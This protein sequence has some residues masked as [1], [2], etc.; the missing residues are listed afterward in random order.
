MKPILFVAG[1]VMAFLSTGCMTG[2]Y[3]HHERR[4]MVERDSL[5]PPAMTVDDVI[6]LAQDS[7]GD[8][9]ILDQ[10]KA[11]HSRF[12]LSN[13]D[14]RDLKKNGVSDKIVRAMIK[15]ASEPPAKSQTVASQ[16]YYWYPDYYWYPY[17]SFYSPWYSPVYLGFSFRSG[18]YGGSHFG[19]G[20]IRM[21]R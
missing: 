14:I 16:N 11:T 7:V 6:A 19:V 1:C 9:V 15:T 18:Y 21:H 12:Q 4:Q 3:A 17:P 10:I 13:N 20:R 5:A 8:D 2:Y